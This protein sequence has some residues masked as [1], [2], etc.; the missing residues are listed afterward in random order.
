MVWGYL[1]SSRFNGISSGISAWPGMWWLARSNLHPDLWCYGPIKVCHMLSPFRASNI[2]AGHD[3][4]HLIC[5][6]L[7]LDSLVNWSRIIEL[8]SVLCLSGATYVA[9][10]SILPFP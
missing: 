1:S 4:S 5:L 6:V 9:V 8:A 7:G 3:R 2:C 10:M